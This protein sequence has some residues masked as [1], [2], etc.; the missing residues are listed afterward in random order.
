[1]NC[2]WSTRT[3]R[4]CST[5]SS[6]GAG[7]SSPQ[8]PNIRKCHQGEQVCDIFLNSISSFE[9]PGSPKTII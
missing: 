1:M 4:T 2:Q 7:M 5:M 3:S 6:R 8:A 9:S